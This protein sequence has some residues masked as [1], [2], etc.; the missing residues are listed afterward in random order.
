MRKIIIVN[1]KRTGAAMVF[2]VILML[3]VG[4]L[5]MSMAT[6]FSSNLR[7]TKYQQD[8]LEAYYLAYSGALVVYEALLEDY[9]KIYVLTEDDG[10]TLDTQYLS[11]DNGDAIV[12]AVLSTDSNFEDFIKIVSI[13]TLS[14]NNFEYTRIMYF[15]PA[16]PL[17]ILWKSN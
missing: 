12:T 16:N 3:V 9:N 10:G 14:R 5:S 11:F 8:S 17:D 6:V 13:A 2:V 15:D 1:K 7:Q 4:I